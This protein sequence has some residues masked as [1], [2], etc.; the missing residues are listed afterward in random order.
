MRV[1]MFWQGLCALCW[2]S[3]AVRQALLRD[4]RRAAIRDAMWQQPP[5]RSIEERED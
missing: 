3:V 2:L 4:V 5:A 1:S